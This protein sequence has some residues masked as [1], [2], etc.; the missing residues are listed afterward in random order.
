[1]SFRLILLSFLFYLIFISVGH[2]LSGFLERKYEVLP[3]A[4]TVQLADKQFTLEEL[5]Q[6][7]RPSYW[8]PDQQQSPNAERLLYEVID[9]DHNYV[10]V[11]HPEWKNEI[12]PQQMQHYLYMAFRL[13]KYAFSLKDIEFIQLKVDKQ[14]GTIQEVLVETKNP[15]NTFN[16]TLQQH[17][18]LTLSRT[19]NDSFRR[20]I[21]DTEGKATVED[22]IKMDELKGPN[23]IIATWNHLV[24]LAPFDF[25]E[26]EYKKQNFQL[27]YLEDDTYKG[28]K[29]ARRSQGDFKT[30]ES[31]MNSPIIFFVGLIALFYFFVIMSD[32]N[33]NKNKFPSELEENEQ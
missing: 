12:V 5:A 15:E 13:V 25:S 23:L 4:S 31:P 6:K 7:Y 29:L 17:F 3:L 2:G 33:K 26:S 18:T 30:K 20:I 28:Q 24:E 9:T 1:M 19:G 8:L 27:T 32:Y 11:Y 22:A 14:T 16:S 21:K 10:I